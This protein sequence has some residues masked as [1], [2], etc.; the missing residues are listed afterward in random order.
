VTL[1][2]HHPGPARRSASGCA[3]RPPTRGPPS[4]TA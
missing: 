4:R 2:R 1:E 3:R